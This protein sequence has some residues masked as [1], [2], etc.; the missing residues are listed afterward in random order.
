MILIFVGAIVVN[1]Q[2]T[3]F[4]APSGAPSADTNAPEPINISDYS[5]IKSGAFGING[6]LQA[7]SNAIVSGNLG[8][9]TAETPYQLS[10]LGNIG[11]LS[12]VSGTTQPG[13]GK[14]LIL[15]SPATSGITAQIS[16][17]NNCGP[18]F[19][20]DDGTPLP[21][22][23]TDDTKDGNANDAY[24]C[25]STD[26][27]ITYNNDVK[28][29]C[30]VTDPTTK[31]EETKEGNTN[32][33]GA[34]TKWSQYSATITC[35]SGTSKY[36]IRSNNGVF[37]FVNNNS[38]PTMSL[39]QEGNLNIV[40]G[41]SAASGLS[42]WTTSGSNIYYNSGNVGIGTDSPDTKLTLR[43]S[44]RLVR[45]PSIKAAGS[46][47]SLIL[48][49][50]SS[51]QTFRNIGQASDCNSGATGFGNCTTEQD[52]A[53]SNMETAKDADCSGKTAGK[54]YTDIYK[55]TGGFYKKQIMECD[56]GTASYAIRTN[57]GTLEFVAGNSAQFSVDQ[58]GN[59]VFVG[60]VKANKFSTGDLI[61]NHDGRPVWVM[62]EDENGLYVTSPITGKKYKMMMEEIK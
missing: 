8:I 55:T 60:D 59:A 43:G 14:E 23:T 48:E 15:E 52:T 38:T 44:L 62:D 17:W 12:G 6:I 11:L 19:S 39:D 51:D 50:P 5:Q 35:V 3:S 22:P 36:S 4:N 28:V 58:S 41:I 29:V 47:E 34:T 20:L 21:C 13:P 61:F 31:K 37:E 10:V 26:G 24:V 45:D 57:D 2:S 32:C 53:D 7:F 25:E 16:G 33:S 40:G 27:G 54:Q 42:Q 1:G 49:S 9:G 18:G 56:A 30:L 46:G